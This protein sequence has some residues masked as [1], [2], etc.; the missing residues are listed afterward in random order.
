M[1]VYK[2]R[3]N[4]V[5]T[6]Y[7]IYTFIYYITGCLHHEFIISLFGTTL[8]SDCSNIVFKCHYQKFSCLLKVYF[9]DF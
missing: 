5:C 3:L 7:K 6:S 2:E 9:V 8:D 1:S 4:H